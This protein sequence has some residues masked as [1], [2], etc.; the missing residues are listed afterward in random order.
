L[1]NPGDIVLR[2]AKPSQMAHFFAVSHH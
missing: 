2:D 1:D